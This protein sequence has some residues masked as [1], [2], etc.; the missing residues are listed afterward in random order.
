MSIA[1]T[2]DGVAYTIPSPGQGEWATSLNA[3]LVALGAASGVGALPLSIGVLDAASGGGTSGTGNSTQTAHFATKVGDTG[4]AVVLSP[5]SFTVPA[6][7]RYAVDFHVG[8]VTNDPSVAAALSGELQLLN[9]ATLILAGKFV[10]LGINQAQFFAPSIDGCV[11]LTAGDV[12]TLKTVISD[13]SGAGWHIQGQGYCTHGRIL[14][15]S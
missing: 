9:G 1:V 12:L 13:A 15:V 5:F 7:G 14:R 4:N 3:Y 6:T 10:S 8:I 11:D 2:V